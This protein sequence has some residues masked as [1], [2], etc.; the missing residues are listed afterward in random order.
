[1]D[2]ENV[3]NSFKYTTKHKR[4]WDIHL[5]ID[6]NFKEAISGCWKNLFI[7]K[8]KRCPCCN[9]SRCLQGTMPSKCWGC[10]GKGIKIIKAGP[11]L[12]E[13]ECE[14]CEGIGMTIK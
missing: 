9:G 7:K 12:E 5:K 2:F 14:S 10:Y 8:L 1:M 4:G 13:E 3:F 6:I 11:F